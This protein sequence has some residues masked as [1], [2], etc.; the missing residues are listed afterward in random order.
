VTERLAEK[1]VPLQGAFR[2]VEFNKDDGTLAEV[3]KD[4]S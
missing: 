1:R 3:V 2:G 4:R